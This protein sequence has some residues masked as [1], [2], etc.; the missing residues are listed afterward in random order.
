MKMSMNKKNAVYPLPEEAPF[1]LKL[2]IAIP[3]LLFMVVVSS[4]GLVRNSLSTVVCEEANAAEHYALIILISTLAGTLS[5]PIGG[6]LGD[7]YGRKR[8]ALVGLV[9]LFLSLILCGIARGPILLGLGYGLLGITYTCLYY[10]TNGFII[11]AFQEKTRVKLISYVTA[12]NSLAGV[13]SPT[14]IGFLSDHIGAQRAMMCLGLLLVAA[15]VVMFAMYPDIKTN[16]KNITIDYTGIIL[17]LLAI[18]PACIA[19]SIGGKQLAWSSPYIWLMFL[20]SAVFCVI[21]Y[22]AEQKKVQPII[23]FDLFKIPGFTSVLLFGCLFNC[24]NAF[25]NY[26]NLY[27]RNALEYN[28]TQLGALNTLYCLPVFVVPLVG[29]YIARTGNYRRVFAV[30]VLFMVAVGVSF[31]FILNENT[32]LYVVVGFKGFQFL[33]GAFSL[34]P[35]NSYLGEILPSD[36]RGMGLGILGFMST[37]SLSVFTAVFGMVLNITPAGIHDALRYLSVILILVGV[38]RAAVLLFKVKEISALKSR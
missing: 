8:V 17:I 7:L 16:K 2:G 20:V 33:A 35:V 10:L 25:A 12:A 4:I 5:S 38:V 3:P 23:N 29:H 24:I 11:D 31:G 6:K 13:I 19:L 27:C 14:I 1:L 21:F 26:I 36:M 28:A 34:A 18:G 37:L 15:W 9:P 22:K 32:P 30:S